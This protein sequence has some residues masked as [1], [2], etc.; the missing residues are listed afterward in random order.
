MH[1]W[2]VKVVECFQGIDDAKNVTCVNVLSLQG[3]TMLYLW[4]DFRLTLVTTSKNTMTF[5]KALIWNKSKVYYRK[6]CL[7]M[8]YMSDMFTMQDET[9]YGSNYG[10]Q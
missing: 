6:I 8:N 4:P 7:Y 5:C 10:M 9:L 1:M 2:Y 3:A